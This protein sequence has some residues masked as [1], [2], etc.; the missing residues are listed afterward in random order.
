MLTKSFGVTGWVSG[1]MVLLRRAS[2]VAFHF[3]FTSFFPPRS[4]HL[5]LFLFQVG[6][7]GWD[8]PS[9]VRAPRTDKTKLRPG[10]SDLPA[11]PVAFVWE[12]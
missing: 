9:S 5:I 11:T 12:S 6:Y 3:P 4:R 2:P 10:L 1:Y 7:V 8:E